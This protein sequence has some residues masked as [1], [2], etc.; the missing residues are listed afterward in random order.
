MKKIIVS[1]VIAALLL[2]CVAFA[3]G[4]PWDS[5]SVK[6]TL[7]ESFSDR[8]DGK[9]TWDSAKDGFWTGTA[10]YEWPEA[11]W[12]NGQIVFTDF[13]GLNDGG[14]TRM[15]FRIQTNEIQNV[16]A[17]GSVGVGFYVENNTAKVQSVGFYMVGGSKCCLRND[18]GS[19]VIFVSKKTGQITEFTATDKDMA[20][21]PAG[22]K[23]WVL[24]FYDE[25]TNLWSSEEYD[26]ATNP[27]RMPGFEL[28]NL[29][30]DGSKGETVVIDNVFFFGEGC[31][32]SHKDI[33]LNGGSL[34]QT[35]QN[36]Q[37]VSTPT[38]TPVEPTKTPTQTPT[39]A[40]VE[41]TKAPAQT[42]T[43]A[44]TEAPTEVITEAPVQTEA[45]TQ[46]PDVSKDA[47]NIDNSNFNASD[48]IVY[49]AAAII[50][51]AAVVAAVMILRK[52]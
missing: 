18:A 6:I 45:P 17:A 52:K 40:P 12:K 11:E 30:I 2:S 22:E 5:N 50:L 51:I 23:G 31:V 27:I 39:K 48:V 36:T 20:M 21:I 25:F 32:E 44:P 7:A 28:T 10:F 41:S 9:I 38:Q 42:P 16:S 19:K 37:S 47:D 33:V 15:T 43:K 29:L 14:D 3:A 34:P 26:P 49:V 4:T 35:P 13:A 8:A 46:Q 24:S 1:I